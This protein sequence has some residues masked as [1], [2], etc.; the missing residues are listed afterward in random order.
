MESTNRSW[1]LLQTWPVRRAYAL[2][3]VHTASGL[4]EA[5]QLTSCYSRL[6][7]EIS[8]NSGHDSKLAR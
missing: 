5:N 1:G 7:N 8:K 3:V 2:A 6:R 4:V